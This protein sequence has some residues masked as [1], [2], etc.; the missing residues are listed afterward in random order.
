MEI[1]RKKVSEVIDLPMWIDAPLRIFFSLFI[2]SL[3]FVLNFW[4]YE[5]IGLW[6]LA[7]YFITVF[8]FIFYATLA[9]E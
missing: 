6:V 4:L 3:I 9:D 5:K 7:P 8:L 1:S 2:T